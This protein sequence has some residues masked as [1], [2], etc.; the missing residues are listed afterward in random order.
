MV[1]LAEGDEMQQ[2]RIEFRSM[3]VYYMNIEE[4][5]NIEAKIDRK[6]WYHDI[7]AYIK[8]GE[9]QSRVV[10]GERKFIK[11][12]VCRFFLSGDALY[13]RNHDTTL[14]WCVDAP[15]ASHLM[16]E[17]YGGLLGAHSIGSLLA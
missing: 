4:C 15:E 12:M 14:L 16:E 6:P 11:H 1:K 8:N 17:M 2:L 5:M 9:Y 13:K 7:K 3:L 10:D